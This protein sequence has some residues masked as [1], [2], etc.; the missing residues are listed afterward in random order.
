VFLNGYIY[1]FD[2]SIFTCIDAKTGEPTWKA[3]RYGYG[4]VLAASGHLVITGEQGEVVLL[5]ADP[6]GHKEVAKFQA[7][8]GRT[9]NIPAIAD[10]RLFV[11][12]G[13]EMVAYKIS[14]Q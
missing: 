10:G 9:W 8:E 3:G 6:A 1:G 7:L 13:T 12:N 11:R 5:K 4:Q 14:A 2:E